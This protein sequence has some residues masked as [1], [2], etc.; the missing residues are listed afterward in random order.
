MKTKF[1]FIFILFVLP[2][3]LVGQIPMEGLV[4][5]YPLRENG[6]DASGNGH[7]LTNVNVTFIPGAVHNPDALHANFSGTNSYMYYNKSQFND[8]F[9]LQN[10]TISAWSRLESK[11][12][13]YA[14]IFEI[15][16]SNFMR[17][18]LPVSGDLSLQAGYRYGNGLNWVTENLT[19]EDFDFFNEWHHYVIT[20]ERSNNVR[21]LTLFVD[22]KLEFS[23]TVIFNLSVL[24][25]PAD[26]LVHIGGR[27]GT[28]LL[29]LNGGLL[30]VCYY[31][32]ILETSEIQQLY[33]YTLAGPSSIS[34]PVVKHEIKLWPNPAK[35]ELYHNLEQGAPWTIYDIF[36]REV[37]KGISS[38]DAIDT[39]TFPG[40]MYFV[41][42]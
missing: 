35:S 14:N 23:K 39:S 29:N 9:N 27:P 31:N 42:G 15:G 37:S 11:E 28:D 2:C 40:G 16:E 8:S 38:G 33:N 6:N 26:S 36:G 7:H 12:N 41:V 34:E 4:A 10:Y 24:Y 21:Y 1:T 22:G 19:F 25:Q 30:D 20:S 5:H 13:L 17:Y 3:F 18:F 32:R